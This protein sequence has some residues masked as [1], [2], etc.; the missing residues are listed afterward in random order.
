VAK[1]VPYLTKKQKAARMAWARKFQDFTMED[2]SNIIWSDECYIYLGDNHG[3]I[4]VTRRP[5][6][7]MEEDCLIPTFKQSSVRVMVWGSIMH[8]VKGP[9]IVLEYP[10]GKGGGMNSKRYREQVLD[11]VL[12]DYWKKVKAKKKSVKFQQDNAPSHTSK[13]T[14]KWL[15]SHRIK[16]FPHPSSSPD[17]SPI[18]PVWHELKKDIRQLPHPPSTVAQLREAVHT[19]WDRMDIERI[20]KYTRTMPD[21]VEAVKAGKGGHTKY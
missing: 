16:L 19:V 10:G 17:I 3:Q 1:K 5:D 20:S 18:E 4:Y 12:L 7:K 11:R 6:E 8:G 9:L 13:S 14:K 2:W 15:A 21:R